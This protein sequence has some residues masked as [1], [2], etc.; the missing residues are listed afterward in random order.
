M[1][2]APQIAGGQERLQGYQDVLGRKALKRLVAPVTDY[3]Q[4]AGRQAMEQLLKANP[5]LDAVFAASDLLASGAFVELRRAGR[6]VPEDCTE[7]ITFFN[8]SGA[9]IYLDDDGNQIGYEDTFT[10]I[11]LCRDHYGA[12]GLGDDY[13]D[14]F[15]R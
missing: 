5:D 10:K 9:M 13:V 3:S 8:I 4:E 6:R 14:Q 7:M 12:N 2:S 11:Q 15:I 1:D